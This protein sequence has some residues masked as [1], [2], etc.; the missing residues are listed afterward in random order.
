MLPGPPD[1]M[2]TWGM[3]AGA[4]GIVA[5]L[6]SGTA[7]VVY[8][9]LSDRAAARREA[10]ELHRPPEREIPRFQPD[11]ARPHYLSELEAVTR[12]SEAPE[13]ALAADVRHRITDQ[14]RTSPTFPAGWPDRGFVTDPGSG[15][16]VLHSPLVLVCDDEV[17]TMREL[18]PAVRR[19]KAADQPLVVVAPRLSAEVQATL[20]A[21]LIQGTFRS[22]PVRLGDAG[23]RRSLCSLTGAQ[24]AAASDLRAGHVPATSL[25]QCETWVSDAETSWVVLTPS[26]GLK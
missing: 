11:T 26:Q 10:E 19:A 20:R 5:V 6:V 12:P 15:W 22:L 17:T 23:L 13:T 7:V 1:G 16:C 14:L 21:N 18:L 9:W 24:P 25:G 2:H 3:D 8:G 4:G